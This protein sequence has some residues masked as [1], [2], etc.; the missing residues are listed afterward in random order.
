MTRNDLIH[1]SH[2]TNLWCNTKS[3]YFHNSWWQDI[4][5]K[6]HTKLWWVTLLIVHQHVE[7]HLVSGVG[8]KNEANSSVGVDPGDCW[9]CLCAMTSPPLYG[10]S[11]LGKSTQEVEVVQIFVG[12][13]LPAC[14]RAEREI[15]GFIRFTWLLQ[16]FLFLITF[17]RLL[18]CFFSLFFFLPQN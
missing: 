16:S 13:R 14:Q 15:E 12:R 18:K 2:F 9:C 1:V 4:F 3:T 11:F 8:A 17:F 7:Q 6:I 10:A 5:L